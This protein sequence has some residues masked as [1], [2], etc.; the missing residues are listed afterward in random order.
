MEKCPS[1]LRWRSRKSLRGKL[2]Q[3]FD[4]LL[5]RI[6]GDMTYVISP[7]ILRDENHKAV[8]LSQVRAQDEQRAKLILLVA[9]SH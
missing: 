8:A 2:R 7:I 4:S 6:I 1:G 5:L 3:G 9:I